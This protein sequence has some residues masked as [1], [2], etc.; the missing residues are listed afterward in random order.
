[1]RSS[2]NNYKIWLN[3]ASVAGLNFYFNII[4]LR[5]KFH[6]WSRKFKNFV[7]HKRHHFTDILKS[8]EH[9]ATEFAFSNLKDRKRLYRVLLKSTRRVTNNRTES[10]LKFTQALLSVRIS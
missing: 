8:S 4:N 7:K 6:L 9:G 3:L 2:Q 10:P 1:M 5:L